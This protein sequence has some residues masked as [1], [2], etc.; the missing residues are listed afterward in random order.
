MTTETLSD[1]HSPGAPRPHTEGASPSVAEPTI[2]PQILERAAR[3]IRVLGHPLRLRMLETLEGGER[4]V[5]ELVAA[6]GATQALVSQHL[7]ILR[8]E[9]VVGFRRDGPRMFYRITE[10]K[11]HKILDCI[12]DC[13]LPELLDGDTAARFDSI[14]DS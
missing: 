10:P 3:V 9:A 4:N 12:R 6:T 11:V 2:G 7:A 14:L 1:R 8:A 5:T 13:D